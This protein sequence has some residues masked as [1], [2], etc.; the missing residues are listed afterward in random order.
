MIGDTHLESIIP[1]FLHNQAR[2]PEIAVFDRL[3]YNFNTDLRMHQVPK[4]FLEMMDIHDHLPQVLV[5]L[6]GGND[7]SMVTKAQARARAEDML[8]DVAAMWVKVK[9]AMSYRLGLFVSLLPLQLLYKG[10]H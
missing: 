5:L 3:E 7:I 2:Y 1:K 9:P 8:T 10:F 6:V 4:S